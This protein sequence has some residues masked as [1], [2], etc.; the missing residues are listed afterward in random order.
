MGRGR[1][2]LVMHC[3]SVD[4]GRNRFIPTA[5]EKLVWSSYSIPFVKFAFAW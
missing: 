3:L 1:V 5:K 4:V 2:L